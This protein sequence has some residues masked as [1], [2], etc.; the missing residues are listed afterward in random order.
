MF[1]KA[2]QATLEPVEPSPQDVMEK[3]AVRVQAGRT[4]EKSF[5]TNGTRE[6]ARGPETLQARE[7]FVQSLEGKESFS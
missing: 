5:E 2:I 6:V 7:D 3:E 4:A 1:A